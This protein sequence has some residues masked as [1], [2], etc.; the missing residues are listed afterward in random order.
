VDFDLWRKMTVEHLVGESQNGYL[1]QI[2]PLVASRFPHLTAA[3]REELSRRM[4]TLN[5]ITACSFCNSTT[6]RD[7]S[8]KAMSDLLNEG[9]GEVEDVMAHVTHELQGILER[10]RKAVEWKLLSVK[11]A[12]HA[13][14]RAKITNRDG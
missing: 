5:T 6:S 4:D 7:V 10:K 9:H 13:E 8:D 11:E 12:F 1:K 14:V 3:A 2:R